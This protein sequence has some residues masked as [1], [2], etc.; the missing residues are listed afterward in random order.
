MLLPH[1]SVGE[2]LLEQSQLHSD[3]IGRLQWYNWNRKTSQQNG[4]KIWLFFGHALE[5]KYIQSSIWTSIASKRNL[6]FTPNPSQNI[7]FVKA[8]GKN[9]T[10]GE[11]R[12]TSIS[13]LKCYRGHFAHPITASKKFFNY[14]SAIYILIGWNGDG[15]MAIISFS[16]SFNLCSWCNHSFQSKSQSLVDLMTLML[17][18]NNNKNK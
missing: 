10:T 9:F 5:S 7:G 17:F 4:I 1:L 12:I 11:K 14:I 8:I 3:L 6:I 2:I 18:N 15:E 13:K 16:F